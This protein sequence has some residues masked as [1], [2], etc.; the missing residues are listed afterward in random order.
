MTKVLAILCA[1]I[2]ILVS[3][4]MFPDGAVAVLLAAACSVVVVLIIQNGLEV[5]GAQETG[6]LL[7]VFLVALLI[8][9]TLATLI[10]VFNWSDFFGGDTFTYDSLGYRLVEIWSGQVSAT[11]DFWSERAVS[12]SGSGWGMNYFVGFI[13]YAFGRNQ[14]AVQFLDAVMG[15]ATA[16][17][18]YLCA[19]KIFHNRRVSRTACLIVAFCPSLV[20]WS[21]NLLKDGPTIFLL[22]LVM[23]NVLYLLEKFSY[24]NLILLVFSLF[25]V[26]SLRFYIFYMVAMAVVGSFIIGTNNSIKS[27]V[28][29][30]AAIV[31]IGLVL[32]YFGVIKTASTDFDTFGSLERLQASRLDNAVKSNS[33]FGQDVDVG[34][35]EGAVTFLPIGFSYLM[36]APFPWT[37]N[38]FRQLVTLPEMLVWWSSLPLLVTG[39]WYTI[40]NKLRSAIAILLFTFMLTIS[41][42]IFQGNVGTAYRQR[43]QIQVF[44]FIFIS[45][46]WTLMQE[47]KENQ[48]L[49]RTANNR[50]F[51]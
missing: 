30:V 39:L 15:A 24:L 49:L 28:G 25:G 11:S 48:K 51:K 14:L 34:T 20:I 13:Y 42:S 23:V 8:R 38:N 45:L 35:A 1:A 31:T 21:S 43:A 17:L 6:F 32:T 50:R 9:I 37:I 16:F 47:K 2:G 27:I 22:V 41:Y 10:N 46:G 33:G 26:L 12:V 44:L 18:V 3:V 19:Q 40:K 29:R 36:L 7:Q 4:F 5:R